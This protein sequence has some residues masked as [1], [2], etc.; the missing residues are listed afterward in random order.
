M[1]VSSL[2]VLS[3]QRK[4]PL[5]QKDLEPSVYAIQPTTQGL[6]VQLP[7]KTREILWNCGPASHFLPIRPSISKKIVRRP[8]SNSGQVTDSSMN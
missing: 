6:R 4:R 1:K 7:V 2:I 3:A 8:Y 5:T